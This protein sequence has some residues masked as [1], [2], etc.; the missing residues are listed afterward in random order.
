[1]CTNMADENTLNTWLQGK[2]ATA[3]WGLL[4]AD[5]NL[6][7]NCDSTHV[8][9]HL[10]NDFFKLSKYLKNYFRNNELTAI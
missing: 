5:P 10:F 2:R 1:M 7:I 3:G 4:N 8:F 9:F 6:L